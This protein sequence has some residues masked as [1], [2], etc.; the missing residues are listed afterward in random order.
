MVERA[1]HDTLMHTLD[2]KQGSE[3]QVN[4]EL[5]RVSASWKRYTGIGSILV[6]AAGIV[7]GVV[8]KNKANQQFVGTPDFQTYEQWQNV[9]YFG[10]TTLLTAGVSLL[11][12]DY[13]FTPRST[14]RVDV[15]AVTP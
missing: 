3:F 13:F 15:Q 8:M 5:S 14:S 1:G 11:V 7:V 12:W 6:G 2:V 4:V 10:G 9:G